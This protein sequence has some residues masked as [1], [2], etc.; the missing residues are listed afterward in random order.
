VLP[1]FADL[2]EKYGPAVVNINTRTRAGP[3]P[4]RA[5]ARPIRGR[6]VLRV[7]PPL[8]ARRAGARAGRIPAATGPKAPKGERGPA[9]PLRP[10]LGFIVSADGFIVTNAHVVENAEEITV[11]FNDKRELTAKVIGAIPAATWR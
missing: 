8:H 3:R 10:G 9:A 7:L 2:V 5:G 6:S 11:R 1:D 4:V